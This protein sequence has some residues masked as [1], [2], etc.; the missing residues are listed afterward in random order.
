[1]ESP[2]PTRVISEA[3][4]DMP[5]VSCDEVGCEE[6]EYLGC[7]CGSDHW[8]RELPPEDSEVDARWSELVQAL[9]DA[10]RADE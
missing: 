4:I 1:M 7:D 8:V 5:Y 10:R 6:M 3:A 2:D 9:A